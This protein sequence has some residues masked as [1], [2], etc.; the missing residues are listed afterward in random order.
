ME[1][2]IGALLQVGEDFGM[3]DAEAELDMMTNLAAA[4]TYMSRIGLFPE[5]H[6]PFVRLG[7]A[8]NLKNPGK[9]LVDYTI[10]QVEKHRNDGLKGKTDPRAEPFLQ[11]VLRLEAAHK[12]DKSNYN[13][14]IGVNIAAGADTTGITMS[15]IIYYVYRNPPVLDKLRD[16]LANA[17]KDCRISDSPTFAEAQALPYL[18]AVI[19]EGL[20]MHPAVG[21]LLARNV[22]KGGV[23]LAGHYFKE[24]VSVFLMA[25]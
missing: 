2:L 14:V 9:A 20:R 6:L 12:L 11:K 3:L 17:E 10:T 8:L 4:N 16:E 25:I 15:A 13:D 19:K 23:T 1:S 21:A 7:N 5:F 22:P 18:Q 24:G